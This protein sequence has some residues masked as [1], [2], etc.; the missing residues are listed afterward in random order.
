MDDG[1]QSESHRNSINPSA[2]RNLRPSALGSTSTSDKNEHINGL[3]EHE[4]DEKK[5]NSEPKAIPLRVARY[6][7]EKY[8][9]SH[10][11]GLIYSLFEKTIEPTKKYEVVERMR[12]AVEDVMEKLTLMY[13]AERSFEQAW[14]VLKKTNEEKSKSKA[15]AKKREESGKEARKRLTVGTSAED[16]NRAQQVERDLRQCGNNLLVEVRKVNQCTGQWRRSVM[17]IQ[18]AFMSILSIDVLHDDWNEELLRF[19]KIVTEYVILRCENLGDI[20]MALS[21]VNTASAALKDRSE[22]YDWRAIQEAKKD[23]DAFKEQWSGSKFKRDLKDTTKDAVEEAK[24]KFERIQEEAIRLATQGQEKEE[25][26]I[27]D[28]EESLNKA[29]QDMRKIY[30]ASRKEPKKKNSRWYRIVDVEY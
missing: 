14:V 25:K 5:L 16:R 17:S 6:Q 11:P 4:D 7:V 20:K 2:I 30:E 19:C 28:V 24:R 22:I 23:T 21:L 8:Y 3:K 9:R 1:N 29:M 12:L 10:G 13:E 27:R 26:T 15:K 18:A